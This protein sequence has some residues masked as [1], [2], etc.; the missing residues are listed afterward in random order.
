M[1]KSRLP[2]LFSVLYISFAYIFLVLSSEDN[3]TWHQLPEDCFLAIFRSTA[4]RKDAFLMASVCKTWMAWR[5]A[6]VE[7]YSKQ[8]DISSKAKLKL[9]YPIA[10]LDRALEIND[11]DAASIIIT[12]FV[13]SYHFTDTFPSA[14]YLKRLSYS[15]ASDVVKA[16][17]LHMSQK[18]YSLKVLEHIEDAYPFLL[19]RTIAHQMVSPNLPRSGHMFTVKF[20]SF[21]GKS[22]KF[23]IIPGFSSFMQAAAAFFE[24]Y[25]YFYSLLTNTNEFHHFSIPY[26]GIPDHRKHDTPGFTTCFQFHQCLS[27]S[28]QTHD[29]L[30]PAIEWSEP[31]NLLS[32]MTTQLAMHREALDSL[33][34]RLCIN[35]A[36][37][38]LA[39]GLRA[40]I[41]V[42]PMLPRSVLNA[43]IP[44]CRLLQKWQLCRSIL[45]SL[46]ISEYSTEIILPIL[47]DDY[48]LCKGII[49]R[50]RA[51]DK[52]EYWMWHPLL[53]IAIEN[54][55]NDSAVFPLFEP[56]V[57]LFPSN[58]LS[59]LNLRVLKYPD[60]VFALLDLL[61]LRPCLRWTCLPKMLI[62]L[63][64]AN[65]RC[66]F[67]RLYE[68]VKPILTVNDI[69]SIDRATGTC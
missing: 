46:Q 52:A 30:F 63:Y 23:R 48:Q 44:H 69:M 50:L 34:I 1:I 8:R 7:R 65:M 22:E 17:L 9:R 51:C 36:E 67:K 4:T 29:H 10:F 21:L 60:Q 62:N 38:L 31:K 39:I 5:N 55:P 42:Y 54:L 25:Q 64:W 18:G 61:E 41:L 57:N 59:D 68:L 53:C 66:Y 27:S 28:H 32:S 56:I 15:Q 35:H 13:E 2:S 19:F 16:A 20:L 12:A 43:H 49:S 40:E 11:P 58:C 45:D 3:L 14:R 37:S 6:F 33:P 26:Q 24:N 47:S